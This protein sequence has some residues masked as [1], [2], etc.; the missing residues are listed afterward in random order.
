MAPIHPISG[1]AARPDRATRMSRIRRLSRWMAL[2]C[3]AA[4]VLLASAMLLYWVATPAHLVFALAGLPDATAADLGLPARLLAFAISMVPLG[5]LIYGFLNAR[6]CFLAFAA[7][8]IFAS[9]PIGRLC[10]FA[11]AMAISALLKPFAGAALSVVLSMIA[12][13]GS[14]SLILNFGSDTLIALIFAGTVAVIA[15]AMA[16][17]TEIAD[18]NQQFV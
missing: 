10:R 16:E 2:G 1:E 14:K 12:T 8:Q 7:G 11:L 3:L 5:V 6:R 15:W 13:P 17:A 4:S 9:G 18:E